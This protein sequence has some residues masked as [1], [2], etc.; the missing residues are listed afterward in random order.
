MLRAFHGVCSTM[1][2]PKHKIPA[3][4][5]LGCFSL[6]AGWA[7]AS[8]GQAFCV[9]NTNWYMQGI[10]ADP[11]SS[12][13]DLRLEGL[14]Q[15]QLM[16]GSRKVSSA[17]D[18]EEV[19][20][21]R[22]KNRSFIASYDYTA[23]NDWGFGV[24]VPLLY[25]DHQHVVDPAG[26]ALNEQWSFTRL[27]DL[28]AVANYTVGAEEDPLNRWGIQF[29]FKLPT[30]SYKVSNSAGV[31]AER[32]LQPGSGTTDALLSVFFT[33]RGFDPE[34]TWSAQ[35]GYQQALASRD[36]YRPGNQ[37]AFT[38]GYNQPFGTHWTG[39]LQLNALWKDRDSGSNAEPE[40]SGGRQV[41]ISPGVSYAV[42]R[43]MQ[44]YTYAQLPI[45]RYVNGTQL[46]ADWG[47]VAGAAVQF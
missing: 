29:G 44:V 30:G 31:T 36:G 37:V 45:Y 21:R 27:G 11:G 1:A 28:R 9:V 4:V 19:L 2:F 26:E 6:A 35:L 8:C 22:T 38:A 24:V 7:Q 13:L 43:S 46:V 25:R 47:W 14:N 16:Q 5:A 23:S 12:R 41:F 3:I 15:N 40:V 18:D 42:S 20:E 34:A 32:S 10:P 33:H 17:A 39:I